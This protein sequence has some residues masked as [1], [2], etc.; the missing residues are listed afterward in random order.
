VRTLDSMSIVS[1]LLKRVV[2]GGD[3]RPQEKYDSIRT[4][5]VASAGIPFLSMDLSIVLRPAPSSVV[6]AVRPRAA[7][8]L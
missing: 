3:D 4:H 7:H 2:V 1:S 6:R 8:N 5:S